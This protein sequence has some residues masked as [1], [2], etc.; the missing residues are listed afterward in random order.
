MKRIKIARAEKKDWKKEIQTYLLAYRSTP[1]TV[2]GKS[3]AELIFGRQIKTKPPQIGRERINDEEF[4][5]RDM[6]QKF[7][8]K[9]YY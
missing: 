2:T 8:N 7:K 9:L 4:R 5:D 1:H 3:P 6:V